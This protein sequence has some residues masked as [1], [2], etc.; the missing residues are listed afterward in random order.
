MSTTDMTPVSPLITE[1]LWLVWDCAELAGAYLT[2][3]QATA[4]RSDLIDR[5]VTD[6]G[7]DPLWAD[8]ITVLRVTCPTCLRPRTARP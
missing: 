3:G 8:T 4:A 5:A 6:F 1:V 7:P 2:A